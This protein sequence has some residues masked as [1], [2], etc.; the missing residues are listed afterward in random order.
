MPLC[1]YDKFTRQDQF[2]NNGIGILHPSSFK[3]KEQLNGDYSVSIE[4][5]I[6]REDTTW[7]YLTPYNI[8]RN[9]EGELFFIH[10]CG[11]DMNMGKSVWTAQAR[12]ISYYLADKLVDGCKYDN[13]DCFYALCALKDHTKIRVGAASEDYVEYDF[14]YSSDITDVK[15]N[16][17]YDKIN[18]I[19]ALLGASNS[20]TNLYNGEIH[21][22]N[23]HISV[24]HR[25]E[26]YRDAAFMVKHGLNM[27]SIR[28]NTHINDMLTVLMC[29]D[30]LGNGKTSL[31]PGVMHSPHQIIK[32][33]KFSYS[34]ESMLDDDLERYWQ[35]HKDP[36]IAYEVKFKD[37][38]NVPEYSEWSKLQSFR[39]GD[40]G[41]VYSEALRI[42]TDQKIIS[43]TLND[44]T[45]EV[46]EITLGNY[47]P[48]LY[49]NNRYNSMLAKADSPGKRLDALES[50]MQQAITAEDIANLYN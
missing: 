13:Y 9:S 10:T 20:I 25:K 27:M 49:I 50:R 32:H 45:G 26:G 21:R 44:L 24:N 2:E 33:L 11:T 39:V 8:V 19:Q 5:P 23:F 18:P 22:H 41:R 16:I 48:S 38:R 14:T 15:R 1:V 28:E 34:K 47:I 36:Y 40:S 29:E 4:Y 30:N 17:D 3:T 46:E 43:R 6:T 7:M 12:H 37:F 42:D 35:S 31:F